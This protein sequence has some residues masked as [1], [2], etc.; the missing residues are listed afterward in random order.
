MN[1]NGYIQIFVNFLIV[2][3]LS[4]LYINFNLF[5]FHIIL[6]LVPFSIL[7]VIIGF[8]VAFQTK[9]SIIPDINKKTLKKHKSLYHFHSDSLKC[10]ENKLTRLS[11]DDE[12]LSDN[13][14]QRKTSKL[15][16]KKQIDNFNFINELMFNSDNL[17]N[18]NY[19]GVS[20]DLPS[21]EDNSDNEDE[22]EY[23]EFSGRHRFDS[24]SIDTANELESHSSNSKLDTY[25]DEIFSLIIRD[26]VMSWM[27]KFIWEK[28]KCFTAAK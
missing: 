28:E 16:S 7:G 27:N 5:R 13:A 10:N 15:G 6:L 2:L 3:I 23:L 18:D 9:S 11:S 1:L 26:F 17:I 4:Q 20:F 24:S 19:M 25:L 22:D 14:I 21:N 12:I 8:Y